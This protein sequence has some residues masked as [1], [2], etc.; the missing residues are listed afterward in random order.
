MSTFVCNRWNWFIIW[1]FSQSEIH[2]YYMRFQLM[3]YDGQT[4]LK[5]IM[6]T[7]TRKGYLFSFFLFHRVK[8][9]LLYKDN[10][11]KYE[12]VLF[13]LQSCKEFL[14][15]FFLIYNNK[16]IN[17]SVCLSVCMF[18]GCVLKRQLQVKLRY[19]EA[20][21]L[22][23]CSFPPWRTILDFFIT[24]FVYFLCDFLRFFTFSR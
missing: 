6:K 20:R 14:Y 5:N 21:Y 11:F 7:T 4:Y 23:V 1:Y 24:S 12:R 15:W 19:L 8:N 13:Q 9:S 2:L 17:L 3:K 10:V 22:Y 16:E 18:V